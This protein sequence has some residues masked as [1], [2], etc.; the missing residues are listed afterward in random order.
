M[1][2]PLCHSQDYSSVGSNGRRTFYH[3]KICNLIFVPSYIHL[4]AG[5][6]KKRYSLHN[7]KKN[8]ADYV[9]YLNRIASILDK[10][11]IL[12]PEIIDFGSG[13]DY[14]LTRIIREKGINCAPYDPL[15]DIGI[16]NLSR[17]YDIVMICEAIEHFRDLYTEAGLIRRLCRK[18]GYVVI[19]TMLY[20]KKEN[21]PQW[22][23]AQDET[24]VNFFNENAMC[25]LAGMMGM[26]IF[27]SD[28]KNTVIFFNM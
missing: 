23:Y 18:Y 16:E 5:E 24:H 22:W 2:C 10:I 12:A 20:D 3:C 8:N 7:N 1:F 21:V 17:E 9:C 27:F 6:E 25:C 15:Y 13:E 28:G 14:V 4:S 11:S 19:H 26:K